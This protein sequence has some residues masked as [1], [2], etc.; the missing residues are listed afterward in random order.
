[1]SDDELIGS[2]DEEYTTPTQR[3]KAKGK[4]VEDAE[5][6]I[7]H[8]LKPPRATSYSA[9]ALYEQ[10]HNG[11]IE[12]EPEYQREVVWPEVRQIN[13]IDSLF[14]N[15]YIP[16]IIFAVKFHSDGTERRI[17][18][19][20]K[21]RLTSLHRF[22]EGEIPFQ[23]MD[24]NEKMYYKDTGAAPPGKG[25]N[26]VKKLVP[27]K[28]RRM[29]ANKQIVC[30]EYSDLK[31]ED[32]REI[33]KR[34]Q[35]GLALTPAEKLRAISSDR[36]RFIVA[37]ME[38]HIRDPSPL[39]PA[40]LDWDQSRG[41][42]FRCVA[43]AIQAFTRY[44]AAKAIPT[45][46]ATA[47]WLS[48]PDFSDDFKEQMEETFTTFGKLVTMAKGGRGQRRPFGGRYKHVAP[49]EF[50]CLALLIAVHKDKLSQAQLA[51]AIVGMR[52]E[53]REIHPDIRMNSKVSG[54]MMKYIKEI[55]PSDFRD[56][57]EVVGTTAGKKRKKRAMAASDDEDSDYESEEQDDDKDQLM[58][59]SPPSKVPRLQR[60]SR[61]KTPPSAP[62]PAPPNPSV[63]RESPAV[64]TVPPA[65]GARPLSSIPPNAYVASASLPPKPMQTAAPPSDRLAPLRAVQA[66]RQ[67]AASA[68][69]P[70]QPPRGPA[71]LS[72]LTARDGSLVTQGYPQPPSATPANGLDRALAE[73]MGFGAPGSAPYYP[74]NPY[75]AG[76]GTS[77]P[78]SSYSSVGGYPPQDRGR[79]MSGSDPRH[80]DNPPT[81]PRYDGSRNGSGS[82]GSGTRRDNREY[83]RGYGEDS[84]GYQR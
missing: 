79:R 17:C 82:W 45:I 24:S 73:K 2:E 59:S 74:N 78:R 53:A 43:Q 32:E 66:A 81:A 52:D 29:F 26:K 30:V 62:A 13:L 80:P 31:D 44:P 56:V 42:D 19:D 23:D 36:V 27:E 70:R 18:I 35:L 16:P 40:T 22:M 51:A 48:Q 20:G 12:L 57:G 49:V 11:D 28:Y 75:A 50:I 7:H 61:S 3:K 63:K 33:F 55:K 37:L 67:A 65:S 4:K 76:L 14:R 46:Q 84:A 58:D 5:Y 10:I 69:A 64:S 21:Q 8:A 54:T 41:S 71:A 47:K 72:H 38:R 6:Q 1:M 83:D 60:R 15:F 25:K 34:V 9:Q 68:S 77:S 39:G